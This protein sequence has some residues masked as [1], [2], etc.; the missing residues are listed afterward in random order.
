MVVSRRD[1]VLARV[2]VPGF[3]VAI[4]AFVAV[5]LASLYPW[6]EPGFDMHAYWLTR[7]G[8][9]Y[10]MTRPGEIGAFLYSPA[11]AQVIAPLVALPWP[12]FAALWT[13]L[14]AAPLIWLTGAR[15]LWLLLVPPVLVSIAVGQLDSFLALAIVVGMRRPAAWA[16]VLLTKVTPGIGLLWFLVRREW[17]S[18][19]IA[20]WATA[21]IF[22]ISS[23]IDP[24]SWSGWL[25]MLSRH[26]F[27]LHR[28]GFFI[29]VSLW[30]RLPVAAAIVIWGARTDRRWALP[31]AAWLAMP[32]LWLNSLA[33]LVAAWPLSAAGAESP[34]GAWLRSG[35]LVAPA[36]TAWA[37]L[38]WARVVQRVRQANQLDWPR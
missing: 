3:V 12:I 36:T 19:G 13:A 24:S 27:P 6:V 1:R 5:R 22:A 20:I 18:L 11:F 7:Y 17:Q 16:F 9:D 4:G 38:A 30:A 25:T 35:R 8:L 21:A 14:V 28:D 34:A 15:V 26:E 10:S 29:D 2:S 33:I 23:A 31:I 37:S 32:T